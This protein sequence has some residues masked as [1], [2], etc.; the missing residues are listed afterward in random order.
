MTYDVYYNNK[1]WCDDRAQRMRWDDLVE[2]AAAESKTSEVASF[3][4]DAADFD[5]VASVLGGVP[6]GCSSVSEVWIA[7]QNTDTSWRQNPRLQDK[8]ATHEQTRS[9]AVGDIVLDAQGVSWLCL[10]IGWIQV[11]VDWGK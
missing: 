1:R 5:L 7:M 6:G 10:P 9:M 8:S 2:K 11:N 3:V 4:A